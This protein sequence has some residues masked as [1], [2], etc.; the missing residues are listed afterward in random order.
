MEN[1]KI[2]R[3]LTMVPISGSLSQIYSTCLDA[4]EFEWAR[5]TVKLMSE[6]MDEVMNE[7]ESPEIRKVVAAQGE[8][9]KAKLLQT[10]ATEEAE[11]NAKVKETTGP[12]SD[13]N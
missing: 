13:A 5:K 8:V 7:L 9:H 6:I 1:K 10:I 12:K 11:F 4:Y 2:I 3:S